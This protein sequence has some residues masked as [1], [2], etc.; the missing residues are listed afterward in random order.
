VYSILAQHD[1]IPTPKVYFSAFDQPT[2]QM[3]LVMQDLSGLTP[4]DQVKGGSIEQIQSACE[5]LSNL[6]SFFFGKFEKEVPDW[7]Y[8]FSES[9]DR[10][11]RGVN[12]GAK[13]LG[14]KIELSS[15]EQT[16]L[17]R[18]TPYF[19]EFVAHKPRFET[20]VHGEP[21]IDNIIFDMQSPDKPKPYFID[22][23]FASCHHPVSDISYLLSGSISVEA[24]R[25]HEMDLVKQHAATI[26]AAH[27]DFDA[28]ES[29]AD[30]PFYLLWGLIRTL[31]A[32]QIMPDGAGG[33]ELLSVLFHRNCAALMD[34][35]VADRLDS[36]LEAR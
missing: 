34:H 33:K 25:E 35:S 12:L 30:Y 10:L 2:G 6:H 16:L 14:E 23:Q 36:W 32:A 28:N 5:E 7:M 15:E 17:T 9:S 20:F 24:R 1:A 18:L 19:T 21:R 3:N 13:A 11:V 22:W 27:P 26:Q 8:D 29:V 31:S 4:G